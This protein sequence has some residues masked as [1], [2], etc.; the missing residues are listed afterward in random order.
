[1]VPPSDLGHG[2]IKQNRTSIDCLGQKGGGNW[3]SCLR[4]AEA[5]G[6]VAT[7]DNH[8]AERVGGRA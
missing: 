5:N 8:D 6:E 3:Q 1:M 4:F 2:G 7:N